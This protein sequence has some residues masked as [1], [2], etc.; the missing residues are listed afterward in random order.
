[1]STYS[2]VPVNNP[3][4]QCDSGP[5]SYEA[6]QAEYESNRLLESTTH[7]GG[8]GSGSEATTHDENRINEDERTGDGL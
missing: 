5:P 1:M 8:G 6:S 7:G 3:D 4:E 2:A